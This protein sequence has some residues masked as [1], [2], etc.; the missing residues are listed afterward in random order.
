M[1]TIQLFNI[2]NG[3]QGPDRVIVADLADPNNIKD[4]CKQS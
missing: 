1:W 4:T 3:M 2:V